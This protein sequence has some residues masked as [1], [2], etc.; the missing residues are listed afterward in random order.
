MWRPFLCPPGRPGGGQQG[1]R[2]MLRVGVETRLCPRPGWTEGP[3]G[4]G[5]HFTHEDSAGTRGR[6]GSSGSSQ[7]I[8]LQFL[9]DLS[10]WGRIPQGVLMGPLPLCHLGPRVHTFDPF[11]PTGVCPPFSPPSSQSGPPLAL[12]WSYV[13]SEGASCLCGKRQR[14]AAFL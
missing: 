6:S 2:G 12:K 4:E 11:P 5:G 9:T 10:L 14:R 3:C 8:N 13:R 1:G 7:E